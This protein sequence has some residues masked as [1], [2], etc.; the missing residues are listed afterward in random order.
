MTAPTI[1]PEQERIARTT[2]LD[3]WALTRMLK[4]W[5][6]MDPQDLQN[7]YVTDVLPDMMSTMTV[8]QREAAQ[9][10]AE[11][12]RQTAAAAGAA[13]GPRVRPSAFAGVASDGRTLSG[14]LL[15][16]LVQTYAGTRAGL[17]PAEAISGSVNLLEKITVTQVHDAARAAEST[18]MTANTK[19]RGY[20]RAVEPGACS[21]CI[22]LA[23]KFYRWNAGFL[24]HE[25]CRC[26]HH[27]AL[28]GEFVE[29]Q[30]PQ[31]M[32]DAMSPA[33]QNR[34]FTNAGAEAIRLGADISQVVNA[35]RGMTTATSATGREMK[36]RSNVFGQQEFTTTSG[37][38]NNRTAGPRLMPESIIALTKGDR[39]AA[40]EMLS[41]Y[42]YLT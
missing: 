20:L 24:R 37:S 13:E 2:F 41:R 30:S 19:I 31:E 10:G 33:E 36:V 6:R 7:S 15:G 14:L 21:R 22:I 17:S 38:R 5:L 34:A 4:A 40:I 18:G 12:V 29:S 25:Q 3:R 39:L 32:F 28:Y 1:T 16:P 23:G 26:G 8:A 11:Y 42:G 9:L 27:I 35:R